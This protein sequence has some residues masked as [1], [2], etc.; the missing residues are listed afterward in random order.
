MS[1]NRH[2]GGF[3]SLT[4]ITMVGSNHM[5]FHESGMNGHATPL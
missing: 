2:D 3:L 4:K 1:K 5:K